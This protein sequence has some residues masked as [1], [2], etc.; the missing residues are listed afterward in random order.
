MESVSSIFEALQGEYEVLPDSRYKLSEGDVR[1]IR[2][3]YASG[4]W[5]QAEIA[6]QY[7]VTQ[8]QISKIV[9]NKRWKAK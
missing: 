4:A 2:T 3:M 7:E 8:P 6:E 1:D 5:K 9:N